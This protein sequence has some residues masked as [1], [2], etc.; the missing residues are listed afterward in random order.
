MLTFE[1]LAETI[2]ERV[3]YGA[4]VPL[5]VVRCPEFARSA[6]AASFYD[7]AR[8]LVRRDDSLANAPGTDRFAIALL[9]PPRGGSPPDAQQVH[10]ALERIGA[11]I[12]IAAELE[13]GNGER[14]RGAMLAAV[15]HELRAPLTSI[16]G[17]IETLLDGDL[18]PSTTRRFLQTARRE[19]LRLGRLVDG[20]LEFS[21]LD[22][23]TRRLSPVCDVVE[24]VRMA[25]ESAAPLA[26]ARRAHI[27]VTS[28]SSAPARV[29]GDACLHA[30]VNLIEN[31]I[32]HGGEGCGVEISCACEACYT[33]I[34]VDDDGPGIDPVERESIFR[35]GVRGPGRPGSGIGLAVVHAIAERA[36]GDVQVERSARG[37]ARFVLRF[38]AG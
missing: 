20:M 28:P 4:A 7:A 34:A 24:Q 15:G 38:P 36:G 9:A 32:K 25:V 31:A 6:T 13:R 23:S 37:G 11:A 27:R 26:A 10:A 21:L 33:C 29:D 30:I 1:Q 2:E 19:A 35:I 12:T 18:D 5:L 16:R 3:G 14:G 17:Y 8:C 22:L